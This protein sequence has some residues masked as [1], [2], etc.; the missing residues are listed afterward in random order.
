MEKQSKP[1]KQKLLHIFM[2]SAAPNLSSL[3]PFIVYLISN[4]V[5]FKLEH[6]S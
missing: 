4:I 5:I 2:D 1:N 6:G 3:F